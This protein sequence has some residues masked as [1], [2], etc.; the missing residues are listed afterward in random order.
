MKDWAPHHVFVFS[1]PTIFVMNYYVLEKS[2]VNIPLSQI[3]MQ[4]GKPN[5]LLNLGQLQRLQFCWTGR[6]GTAEGKDS[7]MYTR[8]TW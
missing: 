8:A 2:L 7:E 1:Y 4:Q 5:S 3:N 6:A